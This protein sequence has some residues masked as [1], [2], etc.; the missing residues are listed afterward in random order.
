MEA[1]WTIGRVLHIVFAGPHDLHGTIDCFGNE[2]CFDGVVVLETSAESS[3]HES[4]VHND[5]L[6]REAE[7]LG[8]GVTTI[9]RD[10]CRRPHLELRTLKV[11]GAVP[12]LHGS[13]AHEGKLVFGRVAASGRGSDIAGRIKRHALSVGGFFQSIHYSGR[14]EVLVWAFIP[15]DFQSAATFHC[16]P[17]AIGNDGDG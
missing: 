5:F 3:T 2:R 15:S 10:L 17:D 1:R 14:S 4:D 6:G 11:S 9:L 13:M 7:Q 8:Y 16:C 12:G